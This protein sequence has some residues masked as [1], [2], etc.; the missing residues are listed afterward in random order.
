[1]RQNAWKACVRSGLLSASLL[2]GANSVVADA[3]AILKLPPDI[4]FKGPAGAVQIAVLYGDP[5][6]PG[7]YVVRLKLPGG[8]KVMPHTHPE[9]VRTLTVL[10]G[11]LYFGCGEQWDESKLTPYPAGTFFSELPN[12]PHFVSAKDG[13]VIFQATDI[14]PSALIP[15]QQAPK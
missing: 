11:T 15:V 9:E 5:A 3:T 14:G 10:S 7:L 12:V 6:K 1:M 2:L 4:T 13:E 8:A